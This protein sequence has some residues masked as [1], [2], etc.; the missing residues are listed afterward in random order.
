MG[1]HSRILDSRPAFTDAK[2]SLMWSSGRST[3]GIP[4]PLPLCR[5]RKR[6]AL[7]ASHG[8]WAYTT[9]GISTSTPHRLRADLRIL[10]HVLDFAPAAA[11]LFPYV[12][13]GEACF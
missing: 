7:S 8:F 9:S 11:T 6:V 10:I 2:R 5:S 3:G 1:R 4:L 12:V 13:K